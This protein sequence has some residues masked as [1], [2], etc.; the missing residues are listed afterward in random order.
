MA[1]A[2]SLRYNLIMTNQTIYTVSQLNNA[3]RSLLETEF[4]QIVVEG[5]ISNFTAASSGHWYFSLKDD[6]AQIRGA[7]FRGNN[8]F[9]R[10]K[11]EEGTQVQVRARVSLYAPRGDYQLII[12]SME[13]I[14]DGALQRAFELLK[15]KL[16]TD[17]LFAETHKKLLPPLPQCIGIIT[18]PTGAAVHDILKVLKRRCPF[19]PVIIYP[20]LVQGKDA[21]A[22]IAQMIELANKRAECDILIVG[23]GGGSLEDLWA[24]NEEIVARAIFTSAIPI[25]SAVGHEV[26]VTIADFVADIRAPT[27][28]AA[29]EMISPNIVEYEKTIRH[30]SQRLYREITQIIHDKAQTL[31]GLRK[32]LRHPKQKLQEYTQQLDYLAQTLVKTMQQMLSRKQQ[33]LVHTARTLNA[34]SPLATLDRGYAIVTK[35]NHVLRQNTEIQIGESVSVQLQ[36]GHLECTVT[37]TRN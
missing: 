12:E 31:I 24:F 32:Q 29:A 23:R 9:I 2:L 25:V 8:Q 27:P 33:K 10:F 15:R 34:F 19:I 28:S 22:N 4:L 3:V 17:G 36:K 6:K 37:A 20:T 35:D 18:S 11:P 21:P 13:E 1:L 7:M 30:F 14:G 16:A 5:E 26:D